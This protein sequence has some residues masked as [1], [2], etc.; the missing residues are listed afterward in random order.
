MND[1]GLDSGKFNE[2]ALRQITEFARNPDVVDF[3]KIQDFDIV[4]DPDFRAGAPNE[5]VTEPT[6]GH[7]SSTVANILQTALITEELLNV[8][9]VT[10]IIDLQP[11]HQPPL[12]PQQQQKEEPTVYQQPPPRG[13]TGSPTNHPP[14]QPPPS[15]TEPQP[16]SQPSE[17]A[18]TPEKQQQR[19]YDAVVGRVEIDPL[20]IREPYRAPKRKSRRSSYTQ[21]NK[22]VNEFLDNHDKEQAAKEARLKDEIRVETMSLVRDFT[23]KLIENKMRLKQQLIDSNLN[24]L[25][26]SLVTEITEY[27]Q[28]MRHKHSATSWLNKNQNDERD[29]YNHIET[30]LGKMQRHFRRYDKLRPLANLELELIKGS[31]YQTLRTRYDK[32]RMKQQ[33]SDEILSFVNSFS[34]ITEKL[35]NY[36]P[37]FET[38]YTGLVKD[39]TKQVNQLKVNK[40][41]KSRQKS[42]K[43]LKKKSKKKYGKS[44]EQVEQMMNEYQQHI[45]TT[46]LPDVPQSQP[47]SGLVIK[48]FGGNKYGFGSK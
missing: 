40:L 11:P 38:K 44:K 16:Q 29:L 33:Q 45:D 34:F 36:V 37:T 13:A 35:P 39:V 46:V 28:L 10:G 20:V 23:H 27:M 8:G 1:V 4:I 21:M 48:N 19:L 7:S 3:S 43:K 17:R 31:G 6:I 12:A 24:S 26:R 9:A 15:P 41:Q 5:V 2:N 42:K 14:S 30:M 32:G 47:D 25:P 18:K 22:E